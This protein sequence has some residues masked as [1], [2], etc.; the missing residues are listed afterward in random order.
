MPEDSLLQNELLVDSELINHLKEIALWAKFLSIAGFAGSGLMA[1]IGVFAGTKLSQ[2]TNKLQT[3]QDKQIAGALIM[4]VYVILGVILLLM[5]L[6][7]YK[8]AIKMQ[9]ALKVSDQ[10]NFNDSF[11][12]LKIYY[13][14]AGILTI[15]YMIFLFLALL[16]AMVM[17]F[18]F[19]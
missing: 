13:R 8:F 12:N 10:Q 14:F 18:V 3:V 5:F 19:H 2:L 16:G 15:I 6:Y 4:V 1:L 7:L 9:V 11:Y 17:L